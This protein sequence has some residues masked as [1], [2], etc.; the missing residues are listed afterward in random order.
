MRATTRR[1]FLGHWLG[2]IAGWLLGVGASR[3]GGRA[4]AVAGGSAAQS[5]SE[6]KLLGIV[7]F[8]G[9]GDYPLGT[10]IGSGLGGRLSLDLSGLT[11][12]TL[13]TPNEKFFIRTRSPDQLP[14]AEN[15]KIAVRGLVESPRELA[16]EELLPQAVSMGVHLVECAGNT[17]GGHFGFISA[18][19]WTGAPIFEV[20]DRVNVLPQ[21]KAVLV[22]GFDRHSQ[23][24]TGSVPGAS[25]VFTFE[26]LQSTGAFLATEM[27]GARISRDHGYPI[28]LIVPGWYGCTCI[29]WVN[30]IVLV[31]DAAPATDHMREFA[32]RTFQDA[33]GPLD[34]L[35]AKPRIPET[36]G[37]R[38]AKDFKPATVDLAALPVRVERWLVNGR[39]IYRVVGI[40]W[41]G[42]K[43]TDRLVIRFNPDMAYVPV[44]SYH[45]ETNTTWTLWSHSWTPK[46]AGR[47]R[48]QL[49]ANEPG[50]LM[51]RL[52]LGYYA[53]DVDIKEV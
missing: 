16:V 4:V 8:S 23:P 37:P 44:H 14:S 6:G 11:P 26:Q 7:P 9:E 12:D 43:T 40:L 32:G 17:R 51:R 33:Y 18:A 45:H 53:R 15:W 21:A 22:S 46:R 35:V 10:A 25:W 34:F 13:I 31:D 41:G 39:I 48:I 19:H 24:D 28:R 29:K 27:N 52:G 2:A 1:S 30:Q 49:Q 36:F 50:V 38:L 3:P 20:L 42:E 47:Y 5:F